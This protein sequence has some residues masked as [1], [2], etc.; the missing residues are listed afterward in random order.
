MKSYSG[1]VTY[2]HHFISMLTFR[3]IVRLRTHLNLNADKKNGTTIYI[4]GHADAVGGG[5]IQ[6]KKNLST[7]LIPFLYVSCSMSQAV[8]RS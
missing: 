5:I 8:G 6:A 7:S 2:C 4:Y 1:T 3:M